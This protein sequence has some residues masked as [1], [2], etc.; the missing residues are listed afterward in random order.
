MKFPSPFLIGICAIVIAG[1]DMIKSGFCNINVFLPKG[2][3]ASSWVLMLR[4]SIS[5]TV[6][7][8]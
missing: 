5:H 8:I 2:R 6:I 4:N 3:L 1:K 7:T